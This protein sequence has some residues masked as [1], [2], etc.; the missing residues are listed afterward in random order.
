LTAFL[1]AFSFRAGKSNL[2]DAVSFALGEVPANLRV[3]TTSDLSAI[4][5]RKVEVELQ[6][7]LAAF[8]VLT[9]H[10]TSAQASS[11]KKKAPGVLR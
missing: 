9:R 4:P 8:E 5:G 3:K 1:R 6:F 11:T 7:E 2:L 10:D